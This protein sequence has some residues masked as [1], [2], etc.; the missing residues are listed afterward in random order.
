M[1]FASRLRLLAVALL[2]GILVGLAPAVADHTPTP[3]SVTLAGSLQSELG[4]AGDWLPEC[5]ATYLQPV[6]GS[7]GVFAATFDV[8]AGTFEYKA[9]INDSFG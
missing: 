7:P 3:N 6:V 1:R 5:S 8:P 9:A 2:V 4:C